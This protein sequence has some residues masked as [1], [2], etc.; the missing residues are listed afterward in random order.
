MPGEGLDMAVTTNDPAEMYL[1]RLGTNHSRQTATSALRTVARLLGVECIDWGSLVYADLAKVRADLTAYSTSWGNT[2]WT[3]TRQVLL[4]ARRLGT[5][6][7][8]LVDNVLALP[9]LRGSSGRLGRDIDDDE[10]AALL[11]TV[12]ADT[13]RN[14]RDGALLALLIYGG[15]RRS[16]CSSMVV[17]DWDPS[18][19][20]LTVRLGKGRKMRAVP[21]PT[22]AAQ[23]IDRWLEIHPGGGQLLRRVDRWGNVGEALSSAAVPK[24]L[25][26]LC[27]VSGVTSVSAHAFRAKRITQVISAADPLLAQRFAGHASTAT[28]AIYDRRSSVVLAEVVDDMEVIQSGLGGESVILTSSDLWGS[29][30]QLAC[31]VGEELRPPLDPFFIPHA[32]PFSVGQSCDVG[33]GENRGA[34]ES[35]KAVALK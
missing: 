5:V 26:E 11:V 25:D 16:E 4:E 1:A 23:L 19:R 6:D 33:T 21:L 31:K 8:R 2:C 12:A 22:T 9:R 28:T 15:L 18:A 7:A 34:R 3:I 17:A 13:V 10:V 24:I 35:H 27:R 32:D 30:P 14:R 29:G 20:F